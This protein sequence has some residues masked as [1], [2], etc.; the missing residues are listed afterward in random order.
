LRTKAKLSRII[1]FEF[2]ANALTVPFV[3]FL[4]PF[5]VRGYWLALVLSETFAFLAEAAIYAR[6][7]RLKAGNALALSFC[8]NSLSFLI[9]LALAFLS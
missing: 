5:F 8:A 1:L 2:L 6:F 4:F 9:G 7:F 3:W